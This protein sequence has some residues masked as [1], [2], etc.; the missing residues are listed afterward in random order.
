MEDTEEKWADE[1]EAFKM[2]DRITSKYFYHFL[3]AISER[4][5]PIVVLNVLTLRA[6]TMISADYN[7]CQG[8]FSDIKTLIVQQ[9]D[10]PIIEATPE[11]NLNLYTRPGA[12]YI[13]K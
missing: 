7:L 8:I 12:K 13:E 9:R 4:Y 11:S 2:G 5:I 6:L 3:Y 10:K 1:L